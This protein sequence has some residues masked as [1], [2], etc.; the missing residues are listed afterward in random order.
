MRLEP[1]GATAM[2][3]LIALKQAIVEERQ[4]REAFDVAD[5]VSLVEEGKGWE[6]LETLVFFA[7]PASFPSCADQ[8]RQRIAAR[9]DTAAPVLQEHYLRFLADLTLALR[10]FL[11]RWNLLDARRHGGVALSDAQVEGE[12]DNVQKLVVELAAR[13]P[14]AAERLLDQWREEVAARLKA[15][16][17]VDPENEAENLVGNSAGE[18]LANVSAAI[19]RSNLRRITGMRAA[20]QTPTELGNDYAAF[21]QYALY[22]GI[23]FATTNPPLVD[24]AWLADVERWNPVVDRIIRD[25][26]DASE[27]E[28]ARW[29][30]LEIVLANIRL[31]RPIFL[32]TEG[33]MG[34]V[35]LQVN[36][37]KHDDAQAM[38]SDA[39][40]FYE[41]L[42]ARLGGVP[43]VVFK[44]PG[45]AAGL[46]ACRALTGQGIGVTI[47]VN[48]GLFQHLPFAEAMVEGEAITSCLV[49]M[50]GR[51]AYPV[52]DELLARLDELSVYGIDE[53]RAREA[54]AWAGVAVIKRVYHLLE[55]KGYDMGRF[56]PLIASLR[57]YEGGG[58]ENLPSAFPDVTEVIGAGIISVFPNVRR[59][60]DE[61]GGVVLDPTRIEEPVPGDVLD[62]LTHSEIFKQAYYVADRDWVPEEDGRFQPDYELTLEDRAG[63]FDWVPVHDTLTGFITSYDAFVERILKRYVP[64]Q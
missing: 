22:L 29:V 52:R 11:P 6:A 9:F 34:C 25:H 50:N 46:E 53:A 43:N 56:K 21:L 31:L 13:A 2:G 19:A 26:L 28:L 5:L 57:I 35:C 60:F 54:A 37:R 12:A 20:G 33:Q 24:M 4:R 45:T 3:T 49:E 7:S 23:S 47:T 1:G 27:D 15:E 30:T 61:R 8:V 64:S 44:L 16:D 17:A 58:Y 55:E 42:R 10:S 40:F 62:V 32:L 48:F 63:T 36:P 18:Y 59:T 14:A 38:I 41:Q 39:L 51:L